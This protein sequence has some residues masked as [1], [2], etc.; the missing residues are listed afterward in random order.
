MRSPRLI[1][2]VLIDIF[3][4]GDLR[5]LDATSRTLLSQIGMQRPAEHTT[6]QNKWLRALWA[7]ALHRKP[8]PSPFD[9]HVVPRRPYTAPTHI[10]RQLMAEILAHPAFADETAPVRQMVHRIALEIPS[11]GQVAMCITYRESLR[12]LWCLYN[13]VPFETPEC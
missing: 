8:A 6:D 11:K 9:C 1:A 7:H 2:S 10:V 5:E 3:V 13:H 12:E 4:R